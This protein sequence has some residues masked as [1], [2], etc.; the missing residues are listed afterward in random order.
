MSINRD[1]RPD[2]WSA[3]RECGK[4]TGSEAAWKLES[5]FTEYLLFKNV[6][7]SQIWLQ[8]KILG[9][10]EI[11]TKFS[12]RKLPQCFVTL[13][14]W[15]TMTLVSQRVTHS[16]KAAHDRINKVKLNI[17]FSSELFWKSYIIK[18]CQ[19]WL[20]SVMKQNETIAFFNKMNFCW[21]TGMRCN[22]KG[23]WKNS[24]YAGLIRRQLVCKQHIRDGSRIRQY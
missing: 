17:L 16:H 1:N 22:C 15:N 8:P 13:C 14:S 9:R 24:L 19:N 12:L 5:C 2:K 18:H 11:S 4:N 7:S 3:N 20:S 21:K 6:I 10:V 23:E